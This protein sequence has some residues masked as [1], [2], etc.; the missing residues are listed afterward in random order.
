VDECDRNRAFANRRGD[1]FDVAG[2]HVA[3]GKDP[4]STGLEQEAWTRKRPPRSIERLVGQ[5]RT[6]FDE[7]FS[8]ST[9]RSVSQSVFG[10]GA[11]HDEH[12]TDIVRYLPS[13]IC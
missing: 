3:G 10:T 4:G 7:P 13:P 8:S 9:T 12:V 11:N 5:I 2:A 6:G 1:S